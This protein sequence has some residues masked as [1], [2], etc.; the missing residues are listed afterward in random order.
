MNIVPVRISHGT[1]E[2][3]ATIGGAAVP[4][5]NAWQLNG[6]A[7][8][9]FR[10]EDVSL[11]GPDHAPRAEVTAVELLGAETILSANLEGGGPIAVRAPRDLGARPGEIVG[12]NFVPGALHL[13]DPETGAALVSSN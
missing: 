1:G 4:L 5:R 12:L 11:T 8:L 10:P 7:L 6:L 9:G 3:T 2:H 13:F